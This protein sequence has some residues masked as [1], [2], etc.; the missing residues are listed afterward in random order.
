M[1]KHEPDVK[2][3]PAEPYE[4]D[5]TRVVY[6]KKTKPKLKKKII[7]ITDSDSDSDGDQ[8]IVY[9]KKKPLIKQQ[10]KEPEPEPDE[11]ILKQQYNDRLTA[12]RR[13]F[14]MNQVFPN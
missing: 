14:I 7:Y 1:V 13:E 6:I 2:Q 10:Q 12:I 9:K 5:D 11:V 3:E 8:R 4:K